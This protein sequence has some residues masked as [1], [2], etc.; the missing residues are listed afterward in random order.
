MHSPDER[1]KRPASLLDRA[2]LDRLIA[3]L[4]GD[5][6]AVIGPVVDGGAVAYREIS[7]IADLPAGWGSRQDAGR[8]RLERRADDALFGYV[9]AVESWK[10]HMFQPSRTL[11]Q[12]EKTADG[13]AIHEPEAAAPKLAFLGA[14]ACEL[15]A[16]D[17]QDRVFVTGSQ[18]DP[19]YA[20]RRA[21]A[22]II[23]V[24]CTEAG[25]TC[26]CASMNT[27]PAARDGFDLALTE[28]IDAERHEF[29]L[30][31][32]SERGEA[33]AA[34]LPLLRAREDDRRAATDGIAAA[35]A[36]MGR[37]LETHGLK[38]LIQA[39]QDHPHWQAVAERCL[40]CANCTAVCPTCFC[41]TTEDRVALDGATAERRQRWDSCFSLDFSHLPHGPVRQSVGARYRQWMSHKLAHWVDQFGDFGC[42]GCGRCIAWCPA[43]IDITAEAAALRRA[44]E[45]EG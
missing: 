41:H 4:R 3:V 14:R 1:T 29:L 16:I 12:A 21:A 43:G 23:A 35:A 6:Y 22:F 44:V 30:E 40:A 45:E 33:V 38:D 42:V 2:G 18:P 8:Y 32:G 20:A 31:I 24:H 15:A 11:W 37:K 10:R 36:G 19:D 39:N 17:L 28:L 27:G 9:S 26:F 5:G 34:R 25:E 7:G 13:F